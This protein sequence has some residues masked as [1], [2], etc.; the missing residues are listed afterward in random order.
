MVI[1][2]HKP[3]NLLEYK[4]LTQMLFDFSEEE[5]IK[6]NLPNI[7]YLKNL[8]DSE[9]LL[10]KYLSNKNYEVYILRK[11]ET[12]GFYI[13][14]KAFD[15][16]NLIVSLELT[17]VYIL[18]EHRGKGIGT[19]IIKDIIAEHKGINIFI[20]TAKKNKRAQIFYNKFGFKD[21]KI[22][23]LKAMTLVLKQKGDMNE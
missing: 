11:K 13:L 17:M 3:N 2:K 7:V 5:R 10:N 22:N 23:S 1:L 4:Q 20:K 9:L 8:K 19:S 18:K 15:A 16:N 6:F 14:Q 21:A 12:L